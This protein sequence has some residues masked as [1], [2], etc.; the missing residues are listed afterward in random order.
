MGQRFCYR[1]VMLR[2]LGF[3]V[4]LIWLASSFALAKEK[5]QHPGPIRLDHDGETPRS[6]SFGIVGMR[7]RVEKAG[8]T[9]TVV[10][11]PGNGTTVT[12]RVPLTDAVPVGN[13]A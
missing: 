1:L 7:E 4:L 6:D 3:F 10:G 2:K 5:Y 11:A 13:T 9:L 12:A 8:G